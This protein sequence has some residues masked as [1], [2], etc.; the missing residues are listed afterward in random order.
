VGVNLIGIPF[1]LESA[2]SSFL[3]T[4]Q[5]VPPSHNN[6]QFKDGVLWADCLTLLD[7]DDVTL[8][9]ADQAFYSGPK[10]ENGLAKNLQ[11][12]A[13]QYS[14]KLR[15]VPTLAALMESIPKLIVFDEEALV[16]VLLQKAEANIS[17]LVTKNA[18]GVGETIGVERSLFATEDPSILYFECKASIACEDFTDL[19]GPAVLVLEA[20]GLYAPEKNSFSGVGMLNAS[21]RFLGP[22]GNQVERRGVYLRADGA[23]TGHRTVTSQ[24]RQRL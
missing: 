5:K 9:T 20:D 16:Q 12:E 21:F 19:Q 13:N 8:V 17:A 10:C 11:Y 23:S 18:Y 15:L 3:K 2:R 22:D 6:Q 14:N 24:I 7:T 4:I 1:T